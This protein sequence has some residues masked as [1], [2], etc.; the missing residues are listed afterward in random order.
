MLH[1][2]PSPEIHPWAPQ[3]CIVDFAHT[4]SMPNHFLMQNS[5][6]LC[7]P[8]YF[9]VY[10]PACLWRSEDNLQ[11]VSSLLPSGGSQELN[12]DCQA[13]LQSPVPVEPCHWPLRF[14][15]TGLCSSGGQM[16][17]QG[18][19]SWDESVNGDTRRRLIQSVVSQN[20]WSHSLCPQVSPA[21]VFQ[22]A[23]LYSGI[24]ITM[25]IG[26]WCPSY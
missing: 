3:P 23:I 22:E 9:Y 18:V 20:A 2:K 11:G 16:A 26:V 15:S 24:R 5:I 1:S 6:T 17:V 4:C 21:T 14:Y 25:R 10:V 8:I 7:L 12:W 19:S 13:W